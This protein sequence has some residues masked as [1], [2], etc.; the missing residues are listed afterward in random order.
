MILSYKQEK[1]NKGENPRVGRSMIFGRK[2]TL[3]FIC[4][5]KN[6]QTETSFME[7]VCSQITEFMQRKFRNA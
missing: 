1:K 7:V 4:V 3:D 6:I 2:L 5:E